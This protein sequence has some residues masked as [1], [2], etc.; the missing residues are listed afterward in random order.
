MM[1]Q[2]K[3]KVCGMRDAG[4]ITAVAELAPDFLGFIFYRQS[5]RFV[6]DDFLLPTALPSSVKRVGVFVGE[7]IDVVLEKVQAHSLDYVQ[8]HG[9][10]DRGTCIQLKE[11]GVGVIKVFSIDDSTDF[12]EVIPFGEVVDY[13]LFDTKGKLYGGNARRFNWQLLAQYAGTTPYF[14]SG[15]IGPEHVG[16]I[17]QLQD[18][19][20]FAIDI[21]SGV[22]E[23]PAFKDI[24]KVK[25]IAALLKK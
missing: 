15:G 16:D 1:K 5:P 20:L 4:N 2:L 22:E 18:D 25:A 10:E 19:R 9:G 14:L 24:E 12:R 11:A 17:M 13:F 23:R 8:L 21:N 6:G 7:R 3:I